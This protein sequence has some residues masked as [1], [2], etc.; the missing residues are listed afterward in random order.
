MVITI[1]FFSEPISTTTGDFTD[2]IKAI[3]QFQ[4]KGHPQGTI[5]S[6]VIVIIL[7]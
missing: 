6:D 5:C 7:G 3:S 4:D 1:H 2:P